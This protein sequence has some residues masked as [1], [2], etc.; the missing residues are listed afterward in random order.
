MHKPHGLGEGMV[1]GRMSG[2]VHSVCLVWD[3]WI[4]LIKIGRI[5]LHYI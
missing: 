2:L 3:V 5:D 1:G 4:I